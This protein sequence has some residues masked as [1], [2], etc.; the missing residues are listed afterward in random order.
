MPPVGRR[1]AGDRRPDKTQDCALRFTEQREFWNDT[2]EHGRS[3]M[4]MKRDEIAAGWR[5]IGVR[6]NQAFD[7]LGI[8][9]IIAGPA[10]RAPRLSKSTVCSLVCIGALE[11]PTT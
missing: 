6:V 9:K 1:D 7:Y 5:F 3:L 10:P 11:R 4:R 8:Q 2:I